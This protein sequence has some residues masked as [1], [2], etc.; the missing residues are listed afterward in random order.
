MKK[1]VSILLMLLSF[2]TAAQQSVRPWIGVQIDVAKEGVIIQ[3]ALPGTPGFR[4]G[5][6]SGDI[7]TAVDGTKVASP[8]DL[9]TLVSNKGVGNEVTIDYISNNKNKKTTL[10]LEAMPGITE[11][12]NKKLLNNE[13]P[14]FTAKILSKYDEKEFTL[15]KHKNKVKILEFWATWCVACLQA[16]PII[17]NFSKQN[18]DITVLAISNE[19]PIVVKKYLTVAKAKKIT[20]DSVLFLQG[21]KDKIRHT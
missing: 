19:D 6:Q 18:K 7:I 15:S 8:K 11:L 4:A 21:E 12:A 14:D 5:F 2:A 3:K 10:K 17:S 16:H 13:S 9:I 20:N 1:I